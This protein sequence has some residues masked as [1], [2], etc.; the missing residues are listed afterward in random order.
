LFS[1]DSGGPLL[2]MGGRLIGINQAGGLEPVAGLHVG[3]DVLLKSWDLMLAG[4]STRT[5]GLG[6]WLV[7]PMGR[8]VARHQATVVEVRCDGRRAA[9]GTIVDPDGWVLTKRGE[10]SGQI[11]C[12]MPDHRELRAE[13]TATNP[14]H[15]LALLKVDT[16]N[17]TSVTWSTEMEVRA[18]MI[19]AAVIPEVGRTPPVGGVC[20]PVRE[21][22]PNA[23][24][25]SLGVKDAETGVEVEKVG[26]HPQI[27]VGDIVTHVNGV[28][29]PDRNAW[30][31]MIV[32]EK[33]VGGQALI[34][35]DRVSVTVRRKGQVINVE[36]TL[37]QRPHSPNTVD[38]PLSNRWSAFPAAFSAG[39][40]LPPDL[41]GGPVV[42]CAGR[43]VGLS[44][45]SAN[46]IETH[47]IPASVARE[48]ASELRNVALGS[49]KP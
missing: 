31:D 14:Q 1:G 29:I 47:V 46:Y 32:I 33:T 41:C 48:V 26:G 23:G 44:I 36:T 7:L 13:I 6:D 19:V 28:S 43:V 49:A 8:V 9:L 30:K 39:L 37:V 38:I 21:I 15:D 45:A 4:K 10:L 35:G 27:L 25:L 17:L 20:Y 22:K 40:E 2:D 12:R 5:A 16:A 42:D 3:I 11:T 24:N 34:G 18:G